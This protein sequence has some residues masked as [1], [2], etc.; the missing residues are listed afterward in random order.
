[1]PPYAKATGGFLINKKLYKN[2]LDKEKQISY[3]KYIIIVLYT[4]VRK[5]VFMKPKDFCLLDPT[6]GG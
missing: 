6:E 5:E 2:T 3:T 4:G 1:L